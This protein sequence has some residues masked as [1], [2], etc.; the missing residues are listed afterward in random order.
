LRGL[1]RPHN[2]GA[3]RAFFSMSRTPPRARQETPTGRPFEHAAASG[4]APSA[5]APAAAAPGRS[6]SLWL[7]AGLALL[8]L[9]AFLN[10]LEGEFLYDDVPYITRNRQVQEP[11]FRS[12][13]LAPL[14][15][16]AELGLYRPL[17]TLTYALQAAGRGDAA[18]TW[19]FHAWNIAL[20]AAATI[21]GWRFLLRLGLTAGSA[22]LAAALFAV[23]PCHVE[24]VDW[25]VGRA[26]LM[27]ALFG[28]AYLA[29]ALRPRQDGRSVLLAAL[30]LAAA[31]LS[32]ESAFALPGVVFVAD[33]VLRRPGGL[34][35]AVRRQLSAALVLGLL[36]ALRY[37]AM[38]RIAPALG[39]AAFDRAEWWQRPLISAQLLGEYFIRSLLPL[40]PR[41]FYHEAE[42]SEP[43]ALALAGLAAWCAATWWARRRRP[44]L[45]ALLALPVALIT[46]LNLRPIQETFAERFLYLPSLLPLALAA[47]GLA[48]VVAR[49]RQRTGR[50]GVSLLLP[51]TAVALLLGCTLR[52]NPVW[53]DALRLWRHNVEQSPDLPFVHYQYAW[54]LHDRGM[55]L[56]TD[57]ETPGAIEE[58]ERALE[59]NR[60]M[61]ARG[62]RGM[63][64]DQ[65]ARSH[66]SIGSIL[67]TRLPPERRN[68][69]RAKLALLEAIAVGEKYTGLDPELGRAYFQFALLRHHDVDV[70]REVAERG[71]RRALSLEL[72]D[73][74][75]QSIAAELE[76]LLAEGAPAPAGG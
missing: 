37:A 52:A 60:R 46:V 41:L 53:G 11:S 6:Q 47:N 57:A 70:S 19:P 69:A 31:G 50:F 55:F 9:A 54:F 26:E 38:G 68:P 1:R 4:V 30:L 22:W 73:E 62:Y 34:R 21:A 15:G 29:V 66:V 56:R 17:P 59:C 3:A 16:R 2:H 14:S 25:I 43:R 10:A 35:A 67:L 42:F 44:L 33:L 13:F 24:A 48:A 18:P 12:L 49:E 45:A 39:L 40:P 72:P 64:P 5:A 32:K 58:Y 36:L 61:V 63:P 28:F 8:A 65:L 27:A 51:A 23:H 7:A 20:H 74:L 71:L 76:R 75:R